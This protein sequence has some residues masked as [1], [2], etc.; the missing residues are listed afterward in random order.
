MLASRKLSLIV[1]LD[2]T[3]VHATVDPTVGEWLRDPRNPNYKALEG[4]KKFK[5]GQTGSSKAVQPSLRD[6]TEADQSA[7]EDEDDA[8]QDTADGDSCW[9]YVKM[10]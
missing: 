10:R 7:Q 5:L 4:V 1:D 9:Y 6:G 2:Q 3:I 8:G